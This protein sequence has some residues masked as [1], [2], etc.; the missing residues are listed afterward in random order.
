MDG[1]KNNRGKSVSQE[2]S[3][4]NKVK[5]LVK[6]DAKMYW[7]LWKFAPEVLEHRG[8]KTFKDLT[9]RYA[10]FTNGMTEEHCSQWILEKNVSSAV[11]LV[12]E[13]KHQQKLIELYDIYY[14]KAKEDVQAFKAFINFSQCFFATKGE[15][16]LLG[17]LQKAKLDDDTENEE[18][19]D[20]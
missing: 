1:R 3:I 15:D 13:R 2:Q 7:I 6:T 9:S 20:F 11:K 18:N 8:V 5:E 17:I 10:V 14:Q 19:F 16:Q 4:G 12:I